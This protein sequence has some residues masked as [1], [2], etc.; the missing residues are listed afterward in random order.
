MNI[1]VVTRLVLPLLWSI[2]GYRRNPTD[3][4]FP[5]IITPDVCMELHDSAAA[6]SQLP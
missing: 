6:V 5:P 2:S 1:I 3:M 4:L